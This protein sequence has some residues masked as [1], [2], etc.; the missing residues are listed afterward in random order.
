[1]KQILSFL[2][3]AVLVFS[4]IGCVDTTESAN[5]DASQPVAETANAGA[6]ETSSP[7]VQ[8]D[9][10]SEPIVIHVGDLTLYEIVKDAEEKGFFKEEFEADNITVEISNFQ[11]GPPELEAL[12]AKDLDFAL[13]GDQPAVQGVASE[14]GIQVVSGLLDGTQG[15][16]LVTPSGSGITSPADLKD[17]KVGVPVGTTAHQLLLKILEKN[18]LAVSDIELI[19]LKAADIFTSLQTNNID[20][21]VTFDASTAQAVANGEL[22]KIA[23]GTGYKQ[24]INVIVARTEFL[25]Q[26]PEI[27]ARFLKVLKKTAEW[28]DENFEESLSILATRSSIDKESI[29]ALLS[30]LPPLLA[31]SDSHKQAILETAQYLKDNEI[32]TEDLTAADIFNDSYAK[33]AGIL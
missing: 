4:L 13:M 7:A 16:F 25:E 11:S 32:I 10:P 12:A 2:M 31:L 29:R 26:Y 33:E 18:G 3:A 17:K 23:D 6:D 21:A 27:A 24:I 19:N 1:M 22:I 20:A 9:T 28:R 30:S 14:I 15:N 5:A 8:S